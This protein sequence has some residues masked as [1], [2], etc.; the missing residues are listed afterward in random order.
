MLSHPSMPTCCCT[1]LFAIVLARLSTNLFFRL[2][3]FHLH[4]LLLCVNSHGAFHPPQLPRGF[5]ASPADLCT[6]DCLRPS[7][8]NTSPSNSL[9][10]RYRPI[11]T[12]TPCKKDRILSLAIEKCVFEIHPTLPSIPLVLILA[13]NTGF[14]WS[15]CGQCT[16]TTVCDWCDRPSH[17]AAHRLLRRIASRGKQDNPQPVSVDHWTS[18]QISI[19][20]PCCAQIIS[21]LVEHYPKASTTAE[22]VRADIRSHAYLSVTRCMRVEASRS[23]WLTSSAARSVIVDES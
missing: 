12:G 1:C 21:K 11:N 7:H 2:F 4:S 10:H 6:P 3:P 13:L 8:T 18:I 15:D 16:R 19:L 14:C 9:R 20:A 22:T 17:P 23:L 5:R